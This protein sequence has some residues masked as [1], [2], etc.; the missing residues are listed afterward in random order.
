MDQMS[1]PRTIPEQ[2]DAAQTGEQFGQVIQG[3]F[4]SLERAMDQ[5]SD[6]A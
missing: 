4:G 5:E 6:D 3:L 1:E 2:L